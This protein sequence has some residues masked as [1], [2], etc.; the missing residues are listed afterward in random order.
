MNFITCCCF[1]S[2]RMGGDPPVP[3][4]SYWSLPGPNA[5]AGAGR[6]VLHAGARLR[7]PAGC[8]LVMGPSPGPSRA[9]TSQPGAWHPG[10]LVR[11]AKGVQAP[12]IL[13]AKKQHNPGREHTD[14]AD[15]LFCAWSPAAGEP[16]GSEVLWA[17]AGRRLCALKPEEKQVLSRIRCSSLHR[18]CLEQE[19]HWGV[20]EG[21]RSGSGLVMLGAVT[22]SC[23]I[24]ALRMVE[25]A[26]P[27]ANWS[28]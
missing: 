11:F 25:Q 8:C 26:F 18:T 6:R 2:K 10:T 1:N 22:Q 14:P 12:Q 27:I 5:S 3:F 15:T 17:G 19:I 24:L 28:C 20:E 16:T 4:F 7:G 23:L 21:C 9:S 13:R